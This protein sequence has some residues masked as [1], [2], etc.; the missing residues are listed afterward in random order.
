MS[1]A[2]KGGWL[3]AWRPA[4]PLL[5]RLLR[6]A[7]PEAGREVISSVLEDDIVARVRDPGVVD[8]LRGFSFDG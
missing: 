5:T 1:A 4:I 6:G 8:F 3:T 7:D 2:R